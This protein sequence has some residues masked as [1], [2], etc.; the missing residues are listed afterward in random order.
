MGEIIIKNAVERK[1][2]FLYYIDAEGNVCEAE[3][4]KGG[5]KE[6]SWKQKNKKL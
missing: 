2:G 1:A 4:K 6:R 3:L 5:T